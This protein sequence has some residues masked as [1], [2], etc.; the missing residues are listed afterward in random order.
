MLSL[1]LGAALVGAPQDTVDV[2]LDDAVAR[3]LA[4]S[5]QVLAA[6]GA[7]RAPRGER[8]EDLW[9]FPSNPE[10]EFASARR[11]TPGG[12]VFDR[13][14]V[15]SQEIEIAGQNFVRA[16]AAGKRVGAA[17]NLVDDARRL[18]ALEARNVYVTLVLAE[19]RAALTDSAAVFAERL[20]AF[21]RRQLDAGKM[22]LL[23]YN[24]T[25]LEA[26]RQ[27]SVADRALAELAAATAD[28]GRVLDL[29][30]TSIP[31]TAPLPAL[32]L[33]GLDTIGA[34][35]VARQGRPDL[36]AADLVA[37]AAGQDVTAA[38]LG[39]VPNL[40]LGGVLGKEAETD[41]L[42]GFSIG[43]SVP[44]FHRQQGATGVAQAQAAAASAAY[45]ATERRVLAEV[46]AAAE[47]FR[48]AIVAEERF[49][50]Q[51]LRAATEN[52]TLSDRAFAEGKVD[53]T[54][55]VVLRTA[56]VNAQ[57]EYLAVRGDAYT[58]W[59]DLAAALGIEPEALT[60]LSGVR[61]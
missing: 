46:R 4:V 23:A 49:A 57:L 13:E 16:G 33:A 56:A 28:L 53:I 18:A 21:A 55:V 41:D 2:T 61:Q 22:N 51:V 38:R 43:L 30:R 6:E 14:W 47:R 59:F 25:L 5:P 20:A 24:A 44:L 58:A 26:A 52:V 15:L 32:P 60:H 31:R 19:R 9:P 40:L 48:R 7:V 1:L 34:Y 3:A 50:G 36:A 42:L 17:R 45:A 8:A 54:D 12:T 11:K 10:L 39:L 29:P 27:R 37:R 35:G